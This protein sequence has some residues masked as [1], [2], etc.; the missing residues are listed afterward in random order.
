MKRGVRA[1]AENYPGQLIAEVS[2]GVFLK[3][4]T[5]YREVFGLFSLLVVC[6]NRTELEEVLQ[7]LE[8]QLTGSIIATQ[9]EMS[10]HKI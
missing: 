9:E 4:P 2:G 1:L 7:Q 5:L 6:E 3:N 8:G 10:T